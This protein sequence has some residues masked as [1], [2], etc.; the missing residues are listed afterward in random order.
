[1]KISKSR[2]ILIFLLLFYLLT[3]NGKVTFSADPSIRNWPPGHLLQ[4]TGWWPSPTLLVTVGDS[5]T[6][7]TRDA[8]NNR[9]NTKNAFVQK[10]AEK[11]DAVMW[12]KFTQP[13]LDESQN[14]INPLTVP[15]NL[16]V[17]GEDI[18]SLDGW[19]YGKRVGSESNYLSDEYFCDRL[20][21]YLFA[22]MH[23]K[24][25]YPINL[26]ALK[27]VTQLDSL[28]WW[29]KNHNG[30][31]WVIFWVGNN[32]AA[33]A[34]LGLGG[35][36][37]MY[38]PIPYDQIKDKL[39]PVI[40]YLLGYGR[41]KGVLAFDP[42]TLENITRNLTDESDFARQ[43]DSVISRIPLTRSNT[44]F[45]FLTYPYYCEVGYL[46][47]KDD[48]QFYLDKLGYSAPAFNGRVSL[49]T[50]ICM[51]ALLKDGESGRIAQILAD[52][53]LILDE[54]ERSTIKSRIDSFNEKV[55]SLSGSNIHKV[56]TAD[57][58]NQAFSFG[59]EVGGK[60]L[61]RHWGRG[62]AF[63]FDGV[64]PNHTVHAYI[65]NI[66]LE[67]MKKLNSKIT[68]YN[69]ASI[70]QNDPYIDRD[71]DGWMPGPD[72]KASGRT[73]ILFLFKDYK[74]GVPGPAVID[75]MSSAEVWDIISEALWEEILTIP[76]IR[77]EAQRIGFLP[78]KD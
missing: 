36:N 12:L 37:P 50:F 71:G 10:I 24:V 66:V 23:D 75:T 27:K 19:E 7:G 42:Y 62:N 9:Y 28:I 29:L 8:T 44:H 41:S 11:L 4:P 14:R 6:Q 48:L 45:F 16:G 61:T 26:L 76:L 22:D 60:K 77:V 52:G 18:F 70:L 56:P 54:S 34:T 3:W 47:D 57:R 20:Q 74:E 32:D 73:K 53:G 58:L 25:L 17:D 64:H 43:F 39:K 59:L 65:A 78:I 46:M 5:L 21:P 35:S 38:L 49:L 40:S 33:L 55:N 51:Y 63:S 15:T 72:Y 30:P 13:L 1:M 31:A 67:E 2:G 69:L 68:T